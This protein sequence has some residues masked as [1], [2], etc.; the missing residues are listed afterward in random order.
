MASNAFPLKG[1]EVPLSEEP[2]SLGKELFRSIIPRSSIVKFLFKRTFSQPCNAFAFCLRNG[3]FQIKETAV[4]CH[5]GPNGQWTLSD[6]EALER[7]QTHF[8]LQARI[9]DIAKLD[10]KLDAENGARK[11]E[12]AALDSWAKGE[13][14]ARK[15]EIE[16]LGR[17][18]SSMLPR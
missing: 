9:T 8:L 12:I 4:E 17:R 5:H 2:S 13:N 10:G 15:T 18:R 6:E 11:A 7:L 3:T 14:D 16:N 1:R